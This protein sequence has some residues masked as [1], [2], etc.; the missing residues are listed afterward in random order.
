MVATAAHLVDNVMPRT[1]VRQWVLSFPKR[2]RYF[3]H[4]DPKV[5]GDVLRIFLRAVETTLRKRSPGAPKKSRTGS[6]TFVQRFGS[7]INAHTHFH[8]NIIDGVFASGDDGEAVFFQATDLTQADVEDL[9][10]KVRKRTLA[11]LVRHGLIDSWDT[12]DTLQWDHHGGFSLDA[13]VLIP[14]WDRVG[15]EKLLRYCARP[16]I[17]LGRLVMLDDKTVA[18]RLKKPDIQGRD[19]LF[20]SPVEFMDRLAKLIPP[21][22]VHRHRYHGVLAP[23]S[24]MRGRV[25][26]TAG[27]TRALIQQDAREKMGIEQ[28]GQGPG[29][30]QADRSVLVT[31]NDQDESAKNE[32]RPRC[33]YSWVMLIARIYEVMPLL[34]TRCHHPMRIISFITDPPQVERILDH[35]G[36][37]SSPPAISPARGQS[38]FDLELGPDPPADSWS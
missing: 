17:A 4:N 9:C 29:Q 26:A 23:N 6:V 24:P 18:Y 11:Y 3:L 31:G 12:Q 14:D 8:A 38:E 1:P 22:R 28:K 16:P 2:V 21:P 13:S 25:V 19:T 34:C 32:P 37:P 7:T 36:I 30:D 15:L 35:M 10:D 33:S 27:P 5:A 20:L